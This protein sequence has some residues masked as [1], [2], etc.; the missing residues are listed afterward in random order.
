MYNRYI[1]NRGQRLIKPSVQKLYR[2]FSAWLGSRQFFVCIVIVFVAEALWIALSGRYP[3]AFDEDF[4]LGVIRIYAHHLSPFFAHQPANADAYGAVARDPSYLFHYLMSFPY[5]LVVQ[6]TASQT[7]QVIV[8]RLIDIGLFTSGLLLFRR[9][10]LAIKA[11]LKWANISL[12]FFILIPVVPLLAAQINYDNLLFPLVAL[13]F[14]LIVRLVEK[15][16]VS[17][18]IDGTLLGGLLAL[19]LFTSLVKYAFLPLFAAIGVYLLYQLWRLQLLSYKKISRK[20]AAAWQAMSRWARIAIVLLLVVSGG[21]FFER[22]GINTIKYHTPIPECD[23]V[24]S[25]PE[26]TSYGPWDR[27]YTFA[28][29]KGTVNP[30]KFRFTASWFYGLF[31]RSFFALNGP[32]SGFATEPPL[33]IITVTAAV[34]GIA[35]IL[36]F[37]RY[38]R[39]ILRRNS[40]LGLLLFAALVYGATLWL[41]NYADFLHVGQIVAINGRY[42]LPILPPILLAN[43]LGYAELFKCHTIWRDSLLG[44]SLALFVIGGGGALTFI[45]RSEPNWYWPNQTVID[46]NQ[47]VQRTVGK[48]TMH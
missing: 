17:K 22:Y 45:I 7:V 21:L 48:L 46:A 28:L 27:N 14:L 10:L 30:N 3:M 18:M 8:L 33:P 34:I 20:L 16:K 23:Q 38:S 31:E 29:S 9:L 44:V 41:Q 32:D 19:C 37:A 39:I 25:I 1:I 11:P 2:K 36:I 47:F 40:Y 4:H 13:V 6:F 15:L 42:I 26:C 35:G 12:L 24:L 5:R 43:A